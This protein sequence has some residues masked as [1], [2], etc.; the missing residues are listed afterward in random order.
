MTD[1]R[2]RVKAAITS[3]TTAGS[4]MS[5]AAPRRA[6]A[7]LRGL[8]FLTGQAMRR[9]WLERLN[10]ASAPRSPS[11][12]LLP[13]WRSRHGVGDGCQLQP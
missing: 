4:S 3:A 6:E 10:R 12:A 7:R 2:K 9:G 5:T 11:L 8:G 13:A 1:A